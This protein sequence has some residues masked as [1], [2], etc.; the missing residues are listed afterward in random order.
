METI[1]HARYML[2]LV[3]MSYT[4]TPRRA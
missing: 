4:E 3:G 2:E 1:P